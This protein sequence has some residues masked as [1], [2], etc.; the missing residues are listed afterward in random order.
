M[1][2]T[3]RVLSAL[4]ERSVTLGVI[5]NADGRIAS[6]LQ[7]SGIADFFE[8]VIDSHVVGVEKP[9]PRIFQLAL[10]QFETP[11]VQT[12]FIGD[13][14]SA[15]VVGAQRA[16]LQ[17]VLLDVLDGY[18]DLPCKKIRHLQDLLTLVKSP[19]A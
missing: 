11:A 9:D 4:R 5:S 16:G 1:P 18:G 19:H 14:Y 13:L 2:S 3:P 12:L 10:E 7:N 8:V 15:D 6:L 17:A